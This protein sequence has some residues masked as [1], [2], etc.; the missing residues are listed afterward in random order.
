MALCCC[1]TRYGYTSITFTTDLGNVWTCGSGEYGY[2][3]DGYNGYW[4]SYQNNGWGRQRGAR[5]GLLQTEAAQ[6]EASADPDT[7][8][9][10]NHGWGWG[11]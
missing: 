11:R 1:P 9:R 3:P 8:F 5:R 10:K 7:F 4:A 2:S 6:A